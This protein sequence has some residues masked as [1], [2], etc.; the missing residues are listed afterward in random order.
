MQFLALFNTMGI[1]VTKIE[2]CNMVISFLLS[3]FKLLPKGIEEERLRMIMVD[4]QKLKQDELKIIL[5]L[6]FH[7]LP[8]TFIK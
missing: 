5:S 2:E 6:F 8:H 4:R 3:H 7:A 1:Y